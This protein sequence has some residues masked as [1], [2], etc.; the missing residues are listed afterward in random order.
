MQKMMQKSLVS[1]A[2][3]LAVGASSAHAERAAHRH[4]FTADRAHTNASGKVWT[5][6][7]DQTATANGFT[8]DTIKTAPNGKTATRDTSVVNDGA[9]GTHT[10]AVNGTTFAGKAYA[11]ESVTART[12]DGYTRNGS[13]TGPNGNTGTRAADVSID[14]E[15][16]TLTKNVSVTAPSGN[17]STTTVVRQVNG[18]DVSGETSVQ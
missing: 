1:L 14:K 17:T 5:R 11:G 13:F 10:R 7:T 3:A 9:A 6:H 8:R 12:G 16:G 18:A 2:I 4:S 15:N